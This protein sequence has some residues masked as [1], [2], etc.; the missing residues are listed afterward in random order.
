[1]LNSIEQKQLN[2]LIVP[3]QK[4]LFDHCL[5]KEASLVFVEFIKEFFKYIPL[6]YANA[7]NIELF[8]RLALKSYQLG[9]TFTKNKALLIEYDAQNSMLTVVTINP[10]KPFIVDSIKCLFKRLNIEINFLFHPVLYISRDKNAKLIEIHKQNAQGTYAESFVCLESYAQL[11][12]D[13]LETLRSSLATLLQDVEQTYCAWPDILQEMQNLRDKKLPANAVNFLTWLEND[14]F[15]FL[16]FI[17]L[18][19]HSKEILQKIGAPTVLEAAHR[20]TSKFLAH[21][22]QQ[23]V[24]IGNLDKISTIHK[25]K[26]VDY[27][28]LVTNGTA[29]IILGLYGA[30]VEHQSC[31]NIPIVAEKFK[32]LLDN[33]GFVFN[34][35]NCKKLKLIFESLPKE[36]VLQLPDEQLLF[37]SMQIL[38]GMI[39]KKVKLF[40]FGDNINTFAHVII[41]ICAD[42]IS[43]QVRSSINQYLISQLGAKIASENLR[44]I[45]NDY[46]YIHNITENFN[47]DKIDIVEIEKAIIT[48]TASWHEEFALK[49]VERFG[50]LQGRKV[51]TEFEN[52]FTK[53]YQ[54]Q[55]NPNQAIDD[56]IDI[57]NSIDGNKLIFKLSNNTQ[58]YELKIFNPQDKLHLSQLLP[59]LEN[60]GFEVLNEQS[61]QLNKLNDF[62]IHN[63][64]IQPKVVHNKIDALN[65]QEHIALILNNQAACDIL[66]S[67]ASLEGFTPKQVNLLRALTKYLQQTEFAY[68]INYVHAVLAKHHTPSAQLIGIFEA[69]FDD[70]NHNLHKKIQLIDE[71]NKYL[72]NVSNSAEDKILKYLLAT[73][74]AIVRTNAYQ[75]TNDGLDKTY[76]SFKFDSSKVAGLKLPIPYAEIYVYSEEFEGI[77]LR[78]GKVARG[79]LRWSD[80]S[81]DFRT[82]ALALMKAQTTKNSVIVPVGSKGAFYIKNLDKISPGEKYRQYVVSCYKNFLRGMLDLTDNIINGQLVKPL[83]TV[84]Y[85]EDDQYLVVAADKGTASFS[86]YANEIAKE[87]NFWLGDAFASGGSAGYDHKKMAITAK[88]AWVSTIEHLN[89]A[90]LALRDAK[91]LGIGDMSGDV[92]GNGMLLS[93]EIKLVAA[94]DH[95]H[96]FIDP[97]PQDSVICFNERKR[98]FDMSMSKWSD[99]NPALISQGGGVFQRTAKNIHISKEIQNLLKLQK[100]F[101]SPEELIKALLTSQID[102]I[103]NGGIGTYVK[104]SF[105]SNEIIGDKSNDALRVNGKD[106]RAK[107]VVEGGNLG[108]SQNGRIEF[109]LNGGKINTD[110]IDN[111]AGVDCS[112]HEVNIK[113][114]LADSLHS[115]KISLEERNALLKQMQPEVAS[116]VLADNFAQT[117][118]LTIRQNSSLFSVEIFADLI[119][120]LEEDGLLNRDVEFLPSKDELNKRILNNSGLSRPEIAVL[121]SYSKMFIYNKLLPS[122]LVNDLYFNQLL[123]RYFPRLMQQSFAQEIQDH[124]LRKEIIIANVSN[125]IVNQLSGPIFISLMKEHDASV[126]IVSKAFF[127]AT[128]IFNINQLWHKVES[129]STKHEIKIDAFTAIIKLIRRCISWL[130]HNYT[131]SELE[132]STIS[133]KYKEYIFSIINHLDSILPPYLLS[134]ML[135]TKKL[136][137]DHDFD[138][139]SADMLAKMEYAVSSLDV[140]NIANKLGREQ[141]KMAKLYFIVGDKLKFDELRA[142]CDEII[143]A[144]PYLSRLSAQ[145]LKADLY[146]KQSICIEALATISCHNISSFI[147][148]HKSHKTK[149][150]A[151]I[152][153]IDSNICLEKADINTLILANNKIQNL[154]EK[155]R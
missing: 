10:N 6:D 67:L 133:A 18:D 76:L 113:I 63:F 55:F 70:K 118:A 41:F 98:L 68:D 19:L 65:I 66:C 99:Y 119:N 94:F 71:F 57:K 145:T 31:A 72:E 147:K 135:A 109:A 23:Q 127:I 49:L 45:N 64:T 8:T 116:L 103:W 152:D 134:K 69:G 74:L 126:E 77:H 82:E 25:D 21:A 38:S 79:G 32:Y 143:I 42:K 107:I 44:E 22:N 138:H 101:L 14:N 120:F 92:F 1:M 123:V 43:Q 15:T 60:L 114:C 3:F 88:G 121:L 34:G 137:I 125:I 93:D 91:F 129:H 29:Y 151:I 139:D 140:I 47:L 141:N 17:K 73:S 117:Q 80:R 100:Q 24:M 35:Y 148:W 104:A 5:K 96:I 132:I 130:L 59:I 124:K 89:N 144:A 106:L 155:I 56:I 86:D 83:N 149:I 136:Y 150:K 61:V 112:D 48:L 131:N 27:V 46:F 26:F 28:M 2:H 33:S 58:A 105:E 9:E 154:L 37:L 54:H 20:Y 39:S 108:L 30:N 128:E 53:D 50:N 102:V 78:H 85:D 95:R 115:G 36:M 12:A 142:K 75:K 90:G 52:I 40:I 110:F 153:F 11:N 4:E 146:R 62:W 13:Q 51:F 7:Q 111:S 97:N 81:Q 122:N 16:G 84:I 87:Y